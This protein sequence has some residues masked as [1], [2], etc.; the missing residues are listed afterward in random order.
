VAIAATPLF[1]PKILVLEIVWSP[2]FITIPKK[3]LSV[4][5][6]WSIIQHPLSSHTNANIIIW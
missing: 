5:L 1:P 6:L 4:S 3:R 2:S